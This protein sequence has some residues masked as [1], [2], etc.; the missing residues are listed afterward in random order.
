MRQRIFKAKLYFL[1]SQLKNI[2]AKKSVI[3]ILILV[4]LDQFVKFY[5]KLNYPI[6]AY[7][8]MPIIDLGFFKLLFI[9]HSQSSFTALTASQLCYRV[10]QIREC[11][12]QDHAAPMSAAVRR[13][14]EHVDLVDEQRVSPIRSCRTPARAARRARRAPC[15]AA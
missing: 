3:L 11:N 14:L 15:A 8:E 5:I 4:F 7:G 6:T 9:E 1:I 2:D 10:T 13:D 12:P